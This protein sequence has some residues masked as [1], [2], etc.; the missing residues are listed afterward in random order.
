MVGLDI[1]QPP[2]SYAVMLTPHD[3]YWAWA[4]FDLQGHPCAR[5]QDTDREAA[6]RSGLFAAGAMDSLSRIGQRRF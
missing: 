1:Q 3:R 4:V 5:G 2:S 6:W